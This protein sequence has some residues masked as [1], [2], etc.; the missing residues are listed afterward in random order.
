M[1][2]LVVAFV[3][4][5]TRVDCSADAFAC[6]FRGE[7]ARV[8]FDCVEVLGR[9]GLGASSSRNSTAD[10]GGSGGNDPLSYSFASLGDVMRLY[11][12]CF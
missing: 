4:D 3:L 6:L 10:S 12:P 11:A 9:F 7:V 1:E 5:A 8:R 2:F